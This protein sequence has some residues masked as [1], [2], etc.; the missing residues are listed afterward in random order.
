MPLI[1]AGG[2]R[3][4][5]ISNVS[6][7]RSATG[8]S[9][10]V[11]DYLRIAAPHTCRERGG[12]KRERR[13]SSLVVPSMLQIRCSD[14]AAQSRNP[15]SARQA[16]PRSVRPGEISTTESGRCRKERRIHETA[17]TER[18]DM[19]KGAVRFCYFI[20]SSGQ[21]LGSYLL[22]LRR[23][24]LAGSRRD[25]FS[26]PNCFYNFHTTLCFFQMGIFHCALR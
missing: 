2:R 18:R 20:D 14:A 15:P 12:G 10:A 7:S 5:H 21:E 25:F 11:T 13:Y 19:E 26:E 24:E 8:G 16:A 1:E 22:S 4:L 23:S 6:T 9:R 17:V 3:G